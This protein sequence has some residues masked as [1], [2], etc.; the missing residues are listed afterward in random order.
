VDD[1]APVGVI[2]RG[3][4]LGAAA[5]SVVDRQARGLCQDVE[6]RP[7]EEFH[8]EEDAAVRLAHVED[9]ADVRVVEAGGGPRLAQELIVLPGPAGV[10]GQPLHRHLA[11]EARVAGT[12]DLAHAAT[13]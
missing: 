5:D 11:A 9:G 1:A 13:I 3:G 4:D 8:G 2:E 7:F 10:L 6:P 12:V